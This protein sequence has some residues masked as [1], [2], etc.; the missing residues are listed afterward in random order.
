M[1]HAVDHILMNG[2]TRRG[3]TD[4]NEALHKTTKSS[5]MTT[6]KKLIELG[7]QV[8]KIRTVPTLHWQNT[9]Q[10]SRCNSRLSLSGTDQDTLDRVRNS[11]IADLGNIRIDHIDHAIHTA[12]SRDRRV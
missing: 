9:Y 2:C 3:D 11:L 1:H 4:K 8:L 5:Y 7:Q 12:A 10:R 6:N